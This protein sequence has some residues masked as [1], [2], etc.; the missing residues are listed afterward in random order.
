LIRAGRVRVNGQRVTEL[1][2]RVDP[3][4]DRVEV[5]GKRVEPAR[6]IWI[7]LHKPKGYVTTR[8][9]PQGRPTVYDLLPTTYGRLFHV[10]RLDADTEGLLLLTNQGGS[11]TASSTRAT[12]WIASTKRR[13]PAA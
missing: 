9:D 5:D 7:V 3:E 2:V 6:P 8:R 13:S 12:A 4:V 1:G 10:G 11:R